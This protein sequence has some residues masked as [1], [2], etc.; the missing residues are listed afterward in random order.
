MLPKSERA[1]GF[2]PFGDMSDAELELFACRALVVLIDLQPIVSAMR[3]VREYN[4]DW[5]QDQLNHLGTLFRQIGYTAGDGAEAFNRFHSRLHVG[6]LRYAASLLFDTSEQGQKQLALIHPNL[7]TG[8][9]DD[10]DDPY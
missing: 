7:P 4:Q 3:T 9:D 10:D 6:Y 8:E 1:G 2:S 5:V